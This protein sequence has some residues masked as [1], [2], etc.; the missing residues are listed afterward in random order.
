MKKI[1]WAWILGVAAVVGTV[2]LGALI[3]VAAIWAFSP[4][5]SVA[6]VNTPPPPTAAPTYTSVPTVV[7]T[8]EATATEEPVGETPFAPTVPP[9]ATPLPTDRVQVTVVAVEMEGSELVFTLHYPRA[10]I[11]GDTRPSIYE[12]ATLERADLYK[13]ATFR[14]ALSPVATEWDVAELI[15]RDSASHSSLHLWITDYPWVGAGESE[16]EL[17]VAHV[18]VAECYLYSPYVPG[19]SD[20]SGDCV[21]GDE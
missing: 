9:E 14:L 11:P 5:P 13:T 19:E 21:W 12:G 6:R 1:K 10:F 7:E 15:I 18:V 4:K 16:G 8:E 17:D 2:L 20:I 3:L